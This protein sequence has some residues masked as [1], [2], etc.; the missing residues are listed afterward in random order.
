MQSNIELSSP[1][2]DTSLKCIGRESVEKL[3]VPVMVPDNLPKCI[4]NSDYDVKL[5]DKS[6]FHPAAKPK[7]FMHTNLYIFECHS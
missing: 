6:L 7:M 5:K 1:V 3:C 4:L 2:Q